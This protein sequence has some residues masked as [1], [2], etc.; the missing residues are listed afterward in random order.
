VSADLNPA[1]TTPQ[2][3]ARTTRAIVMTWVRRLLVVLVLGGAIYSLVS[4]WSEVSDTLTSLPVPTV[5][6][7]FAV[8][9][10]AAFLTPPMWQIMLADLGTKVRARD[11]AM[12]YLVGQLGKYV[13]GSVWA[14][15]VQMEL[16]KAA[17]VTRV[18][19][20]TA[21]L[22]TT[23]VGIVSSL[24]T[25]ILAMPVILNGHRELL[26]LFVV[27]PF[28]LAL[29]HPRLLTWLISRVLRVLRRPPLPH[30]VSF[31]PI[32][33]I[34]FLAAFVSS[35]YGLHIWLLADALGDPGWSGLLLCIGT[36]SLAMTAGLLAF[37]LPSGI[38]VR[39]VVIVAA[40]ATALPASQALAL[41]VVS[42]VMFTVV[43]LAS[44]G[45]A[46]LVARHGKGKRPAPVDDATDEAASPTN[47][48]T[49]S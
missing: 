2:P 13:P 44:A 43:D 29:L 34:F 7:S 22:I 38:G 8:V 12:I 20:F 32:V 31:A 23:G 18:R 46:A 9:F 3:P 40:L 26:W 39:E 14:F 1:A 37:F 42:R 48:S 27:L 47:A 21:S 15:L 19:S 41:A 33:K 49:G 11:S 16:A 30:P 24:V 28:G 35:L 25:G 36:M 6:L 4:Q 10:V 17:G 5:V 45:G